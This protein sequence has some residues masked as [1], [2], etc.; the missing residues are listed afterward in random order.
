M[1]SPLKWL[2]S[3]KEPR[4]TWEL[5]LWVY[6]ALTQFIVCIGPGYNRQCKL[7]GELMSYETDVSSSEWTVMK[8]VW[9]WHAGLIV[10]FTIC[11]T[12]TTSSVPALTP[13]TT[14][15]YT[16]VTVVPS[17]IHYPVFSRLVAEVNL[18]RFAIK[19]S[20]KWE[21]FDSCETHTI[22][23]HANVAPGFGHAQQAIT[24]MVLF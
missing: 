4:S 7:N 24:E 9:L 1:H 3:L 8:Q 10:S 6:S 22:Q 17:M 23:Q 16:V 14:L 5:F 15:W 11:Y 19:I 21:R 2:T 20:V 18:N 13:E 12:G